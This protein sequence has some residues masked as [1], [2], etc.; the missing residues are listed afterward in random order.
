MCDSSGDSSGCHRVVP[1]AKGSSICY[2]SAT[3]IP[4]TVV[5]N[6]E[7]TSF[8]MSRGAHRSIAC[9]GKS[10]W[11]AALVNVDIGSSEAF[12]ERLHLMLE[13]LQLSSA[14]V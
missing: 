14:R 5:A 8:R 1:Q 12:C 13:S 3:R 6:P 11:H 7:G 10:T 4:G 9:T 2:K